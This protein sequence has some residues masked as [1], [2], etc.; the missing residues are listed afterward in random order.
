MNWQALFIGLTIFAVCCAVIGAGLLLV[1]FGAWVGL[2][3]RSWCF[4][5]ES[6]RRAERYVEVRRV[7]RDCWDEWLL[8]RER[9]RDE[10]FSVYNGRRGR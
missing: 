1:R 3:F 10:V 6:K 2:S 7:A 9:E 8:E 5:R 4:M